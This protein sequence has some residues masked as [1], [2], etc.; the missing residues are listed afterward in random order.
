MMRSTLVKIAICV[1]SFA[2]AAYGYLEEQNE[3]TK[4]RILIPKL[5]KQL[6]A[7]EEKNARLSLEI[8]QFESPG[9]LMQLAKQCEY[10]HLCH[11]YEDDIVVISMTTPNFIYASIE[12]PTY[13]RFSLET[14]TIIGSSK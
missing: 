11:P 13:E 9:N 5:E 1:V 2:S 3:L 6:I 7:I 10:S 12:A 14:K 8:E 4:L